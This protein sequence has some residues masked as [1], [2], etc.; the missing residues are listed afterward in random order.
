M[1]IECTNP[2]QVIRRAFFLAWKACGGTSGYGFLQNNPTASEERVWENVANRGDYP[3]G[4]LFG[5]AVKKGEASGDYVFGRMMK[6]TLRWNDGEIDVQEYQ[7]R[8]DYQSWCGVYPSYESLI[9]A[10]IESLAAES[11]QQSE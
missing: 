7:P 8:A 5:P 6:L 9:R 4:K 1:K 2:E 3:G 10:A 11:E